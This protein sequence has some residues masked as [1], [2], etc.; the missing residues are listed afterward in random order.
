MATTRTVFD[1]RRTMTCVDVGAPVQCWTRD[2]HAALEPLGGFGMTEP[3]DTVRAWLTDAGAGP[4]RHEARTIA[5]RPAA[6]KIAGEA[7]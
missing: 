2:E 7:V 3:S 5:G 4:E 1:G 6:C